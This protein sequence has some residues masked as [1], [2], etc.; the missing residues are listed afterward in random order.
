MQDK[1]AAEEAKQKTEEYFEKLGAAFHYDCFKENKP[2][3]MYCIN[4]CYKN[5]LH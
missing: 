2:E 3:G 1:N 4:E 5:K